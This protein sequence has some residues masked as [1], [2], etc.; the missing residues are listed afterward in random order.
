M[1]VI[2]AEKPDMGEKIAAALGGPS[3]HKQEKK[4]G[5]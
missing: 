5:F 2:Y 1:V 3:F 4:N